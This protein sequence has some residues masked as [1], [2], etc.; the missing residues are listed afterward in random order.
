MELE[1]DE[2]SALI[3]SL[4][5][6]GLVAPNEELLLTP[7]TGGVSSQIVRVDTVRGTICVKH[8]LP[9]LRVEADWSAPLERNA[10]EVAWMKLASQLVPGAVPQVLAEDPGSQTFAMTFFD[11]RAYSGWKNELRDGHANVETARAVG[12]LLATIHRG[13]ARD[14][15]VARAFANDVNFFAL[16]LDPYFLATA[17][18]NPDCADAL[19]SLSDDTAATKL[20]LVHGDISPKNV[21]VGKG[22]PVLLDAEC[23]CYGDPAFDVAFCLAHLLLKCVWRPQATDGY[24][25]SFDAF[26][27]GYVRGVDWEPVVEIEARIARLLPALLLARVDGKSRVEYLDAPQDRDSV[28]R[29]AKPFVVA[30]P[31]KLDAVRNGWQKQLEKERA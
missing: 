10:A 4:Q 2:R 12:R 13:T 11:P 16:R 26:I 28:R 8:A 25:A 14:D 3:A 7:L 27:G 22:G 21:L 30:A 19:I 6:M 9:K 5:G 1:S 31:K 18:A 20:A 29:F 24:L 17:V 23:A 15:A